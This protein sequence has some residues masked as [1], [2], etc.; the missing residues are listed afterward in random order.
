LVRIGAHPT[1]DAE[2]A[3]IAGTNQNAEPAEHP[4]ESTESLRSLRPPR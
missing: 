1:Q 3:E 4:E 2:R